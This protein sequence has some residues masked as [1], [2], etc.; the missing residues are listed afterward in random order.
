MD[1]QANIFLVDPHA[2]GGSGTDH[3]R[4]PCNEIVLYVPLA[5]R[6][7]PGMKRLGLAAL[8]SQIFGNDLSASPRCAVDDGATGT[9]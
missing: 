5:G 1:H 7:Q 6:L 8:P 3:L 9:V 2:E 4:C